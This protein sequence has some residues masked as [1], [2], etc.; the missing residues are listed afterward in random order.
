M[1]ITIAAVGRLKRGALESVFRDYIDRLKW[2]VSVHEI[3][4]A[5]SPDRSTRRQLEK[6]NL[7]RLIPDKTMLVALD[8]KGEDL[9]SEAL[10]G[11]IERW[12]VEGQS[13]A[14][15]VI[16]GPDG[17]ATPLVARADLVL[18]FGRATWPHLLVR[19]MLAEQLFRAASIQVGHPYHRG[20]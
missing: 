19:V 2:D 16:G 20:D 5:K 13:H 15:F 8:A 3:N 17:L 14:T 1:R 4:A 18:A 10:A 11:R 12:Q 7:E 9:S 6:T